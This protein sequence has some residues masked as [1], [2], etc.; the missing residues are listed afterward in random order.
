MLP[1]NKLRRQYKH[2]AAPR[3]PVRARP[4]DTFYREWLSGRSKQ[5][6]FKAAQAAVRAE[7]PAPFYWAAF[8]MV[9]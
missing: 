7:Y 1:Q 5:A 3:L 9:D 2:A 6:A 4:V 8:V